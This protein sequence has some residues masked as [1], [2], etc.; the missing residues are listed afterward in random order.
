MAVFAALLGAG[1]ASAQPYQP[2][3]PTD[4]P[5]HWTAM[6]PTPAALRGAASGP[7]QLAPS[8]GTIQTVAAQR[9]PA[10]PGLPAP[11]PSDVPS[12]ASEYQEYL[13]LPGPNRVFG[14]FESEAASQKRMTEKAK[15]KQGERLEF[16]ASAPLSHGKY[17][18]RNWSPA[19]TFV[20]PNYVC[21]HKLYFEQ[22]NFE[23][24]GWDLGPITPVLS[25]GSFFLDFAL[26][27]YNFGTDPF[28]NYECSAGYCQPGDPVPLLLYPPELSVTGFLTEAAAI[29]T[30]VA[31]FP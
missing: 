3:A 4:L 23:R 12:S 16:P 10:G 9:P 27:P 5:A 21:Y 31:I 24:Y 26:M 7:M 11:V 13:E 29:V 14:I 30:L 17:A 8:D 28:R 2:T 15:T 6:P 1:F 25:A 19:Q 22:K 18:G 20:E